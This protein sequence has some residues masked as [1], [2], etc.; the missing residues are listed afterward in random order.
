MNILD[1]STFKK[2]M[3]LKFFM[4]ICVWG[5]VPLLIPQSW[6]PFFGLNLTDFQVT[7]LRVWGVIVLLDFFVYLYI[8][9]K[10]YA[11]W[12]K[13]LLLFG[14]LDNGGLGLVLLILTPIF[15]LPWGVWINIPFQLFFGYWFWRFYR[16]AQKTP[17]F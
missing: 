7:L 17:D 15:S 9:K 5:L 4:V 6:I 10:P 8:Y 2:V 12:T 16:C 11:Q 13:Y 14:L 3:Y 1:S